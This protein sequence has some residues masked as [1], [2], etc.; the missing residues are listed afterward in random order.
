MALGP[1]V[2]LALLLLVCPQGDALSRRRFEVQ[3]PVLLHCCGTGCLDGGGAGA[4]E[5]AEAPGL[6]S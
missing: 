3:R 5:R 6:E 4:A 2:T 1:G